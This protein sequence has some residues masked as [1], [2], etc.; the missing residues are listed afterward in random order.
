MHNFFN[1]NQLYLNQ[2][3]SLL[4]R[5]RLLHSALHNFFN[6]NQLHLY[7]SISL[8]CRPTALHTVTFSNASYYQTTVV[9]LQCSM[10]YSSSV[11]RI[12]L[13]HFPKKFN[14]PP[15]SRKQRTVTLECGSLREFCI[16]SFSSFRK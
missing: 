5:P 15:T 14:L 2:S 11:L 12:A 8:L 13:N 16:T 1:L 4:C 9:G 6:L 3:L 10:Q 7:L